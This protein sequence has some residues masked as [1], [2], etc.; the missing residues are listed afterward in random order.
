M[1][2]L[3]EN[4]EKIKRI[5][6][7]VKELRAELSTLPSDYMRVEV[8]DEMHAGFCRYCGCIMPEGKHCYCTSD[9]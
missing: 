3:I 5:N 2:L 7:L 9:E 4:I 8:W 6:K 1:Q